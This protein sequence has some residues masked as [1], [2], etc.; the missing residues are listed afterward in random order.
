MPCAPTAPASHALRPNC[1]GVS[2]PEPQ[3]H[4]R[5]MP[6]APPALASHALCPTCTGVSCPEPQLHW[7]LMPCAP[8]S[9]TSIV[10]H[11]TNDETIRHRI[12]FILESKKIKI[13]STTILLVVLYGCETWS[14]KLIESRRLRVFDNRLLGKTFGSK[15]EEVTRGLQKIS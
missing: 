1:T 12:F 5:L 13:K 2:C 3:L 15:E 10:L 7:R 8:L 14:L 4:W 9:T 6:C 11:S